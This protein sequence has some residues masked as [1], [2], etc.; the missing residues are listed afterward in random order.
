MNG[1]QP[2]E[3]PLY[4]DYARTRNKKEFDVI[5]LG[6]DFMYSAKLTP[7]PFAPDKVFADTNNW[8]YRLKTLISID[9]LKFSR[10]NFMNY[11]HGRHVYYD[12]DNIKY[13]TPSPGR[14]STSTSN[15]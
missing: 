10:R 14:S 9:T 13:V 8:L 1:M 5:F 2:E 15:T 12:R 11:L 7:G 3:M 6:L 4:L